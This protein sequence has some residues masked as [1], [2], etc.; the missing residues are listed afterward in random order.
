MWDLT[1]STN[2]LEG[3]A[4]MHLYKTQWHM[5]GF[6]SSHLSRSLGKSDLQ[7]LCLHPPGLLQGL[8]LAHLPAAPQVDL[9]IYFL[10]TNM[11]QITHSCINVF[12]FFHEIVDKYG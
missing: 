6:S 4:L 3:E 12:L 5:I 2:V 9:A 10:S 8:G 7:R 1:R 11:H